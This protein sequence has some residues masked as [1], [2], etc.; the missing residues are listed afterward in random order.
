[1]RQICAYEVHVIWIKGDKAETWKNCDNNTRRELG[2]RACDCMNWNWSGFIQLTYL[3]PVFF[4]PI[5]TLSIHV[6]E[7][8]SFY[9][10]FLSKMLYVVLLLSSTLPIFKFCNWSNSSVCKVQT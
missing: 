4:R 10:V 6:C 3:Q 9:D 5:F 8:A 7:K 1:M 2:E